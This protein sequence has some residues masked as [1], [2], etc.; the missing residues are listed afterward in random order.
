MALSAVVIT[1]NE[2]RN[3][4]RCLSAL[5][6]AD[7]IV[8]LDS[9]STDRTVEIAGRYTDNVSYRPFTGYSDQWS[10]AIEL[11]RGEWILI[12]GADEVVT[13][14]LAAEIRKAVRGRDCD[15]YRM[16]RRSY[17][18]GRAIRGC[19]WYPDYQVRLARKDKARFEDRLVHETLEINGKC[20]TL[21]ND[22]IHYSYQ[23][24][25]DVIQ[26]T[27]AYSR[28]GALQKIKDGDRFRLTDL[29]LRPGLAFL[30]KYIMKRGFVDG[31]HGFILSVLT[32][33]SVFLK[34]A[35]LWDM[36]GRK[37]QRKEQ[38]HND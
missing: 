19:G 9:G 1:Y 37:D 36:T 14:E 23:D 33:Y 16:P 7:E 2:E 21:S 10:A 4:D 17:F 24:M 8:V 27:M 28:A 15:A 12:V 29:L 38:Q 20:G 18:L 35:I 34:Y 32:A 25:Q 3:I 13:A 5:D 22:L 6:F 31:L 11:A 26:K 30:R